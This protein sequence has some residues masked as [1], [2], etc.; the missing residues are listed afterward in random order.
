M[1]TSIIIDL[2]Q[3]GRTVGD[4]AEQ[5][6]RN[7]GAIRSVLRRAGELKSTARRVY[8]DPM[9]PDDIERRRVDRDPCRMCGVRGDVGCSHSRRTA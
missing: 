7:V 3:G 8:T 9:H 6:G 5:V 1:T 2:W 4:I